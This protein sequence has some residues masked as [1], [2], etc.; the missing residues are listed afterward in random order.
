MPEKPAV[1]APGTD[2]AYEA[3]AEQQIREQAAYDKLVR[4][5]AQRAQWREAW[6]RRS[7]RAAA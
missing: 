1:C 4:R 3:H 5:E 2:P 6:H 7:A